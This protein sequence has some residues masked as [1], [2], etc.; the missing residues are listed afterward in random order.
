MRLRGGCTDNAKMPL[1]FP[2]TVQPRSK[3]RRIED[4]P[5]YLSPLGGHTR[6]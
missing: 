1:G 2:L 5:P 6:Y 4:I 3:Q